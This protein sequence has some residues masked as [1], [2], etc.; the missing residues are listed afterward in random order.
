[1][2]RLLSPDY[3][4]SAVFNSPKAALWPQVKTLLEESADFLEVFP[5]GTVIAGFTRE[6]AQALAAV[7]VFRIA[8][9][10]KKTAAFFMW[11]KPIK[12][13]LAHQWF[14]CYT[15]A[16]QCG[17]AA[18]YCQEEREIPDADGTGTDGSLHIYMKA[19][20][21]VP[22]GFKPEDFYDEEE[23]KKEALKH[24]FEINPKPNLKCTVP[25]HRVFFSWQRGAPAT[26]KKQFQVQAGRYGFLN[27]PLFNI[28]AFKVAGETAERKFTL[29][30]AP[31]AAG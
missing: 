10:W 25:C 1:M 8:E 4:L 28:D 15:T 11:G 26:I 18:A 16:L 12:T 19:E 3:Y 24:C 22:P 31:G 14:S 7:K 23:A 9:G 2:N 20:I 6:P 27:C 21:T 17:Q 5:D 29:V 30:G 13:L